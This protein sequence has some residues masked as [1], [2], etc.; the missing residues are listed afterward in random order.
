MTF[1]PVTTDEEA[2]LV[3]IQNDRA[4]F[5]A[6]LSGGAEHRTLRLRRILDGADTTLAEAPLDDDEIYLRITGDYLEYRFAWSR[7]ARA[8]EPLGDNV[9]GVSLS[10]AELGG[11]NYTGVYLGL[12]ASSNGQRSDGY[13]DFD[14]FRYRPA[15]NSRD[16]WFQR[17]RRLQQP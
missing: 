1:R 15:A 4:A 16:H 3:L 5:V 7:D 12:Y 2:G 9:D 8:W 13:A 10:P 6:T 14:F 17:Q 11:F